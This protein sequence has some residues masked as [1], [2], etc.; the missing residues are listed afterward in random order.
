MTQ[1]VYIPYDLSS[2]TAPTGRLLLSY[3]SQ[4]YWCKLIH[5]LLWFL[6]HLIWSPTASGDWLIMYLLVSTQ[7]T[8]LWRTSHHTFWNYNIMYVITVPITSFNVIILAASKSWIREIRSNGNESI[9][10]EPTR[11]MRCLHYLMEMNE[12]F[13][14]VICI[15]SLTLIK[16]AEVRNKTHPHQS[17]RLLKYVYSTLVPISNRLGSKRSYTLS[18]L[19]CKSQLILVNDT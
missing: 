12:R 7:D 1:E 4:L 9:E 10:D 2:Y 18:Y 16:T 14:Y 15:F 11:A 17:I 6:Y 5:V 8:V 13:W 19:Y 3:R